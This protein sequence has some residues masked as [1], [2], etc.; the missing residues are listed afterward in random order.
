MKSSSWSHATAL[1]HSAHLPTHRTLFWVG[2]RQGNQARFL[3]FNKICVAAHNLARLFM[4]FFQD[5]TLPSAQV[6]ISNAMP[7]TGLCPVLDKLAQND[8]QARGR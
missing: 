2:S 6:D 4:P 1:L 7:L 3:V 5:I 8:Q